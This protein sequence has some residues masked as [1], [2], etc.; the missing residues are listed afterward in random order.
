MKKPLLIAVLLISFAV[1]L[2]GTGCKKTKDATTPPSLTTADVIL[3]VTSTSA[4]SG[5]TVTSVGASAV[6]AIGVCYSSTNHT[7]TIS[8]TKTSETIGNS[9]SF[10]SNLTGLTPSTTYYVRAYATNQFGTSYGSVVT[11]TTSGTLAAVAGAV[12]TFAGNGTGGYADGTGTAAQFNSPSGI[13]VDSHGNVYVSDSFN[14]RIRKIT[15]A[16]VVTTVAGT[17]V[18]GYHDGS[19]ATA[20][21]YGPQGLAVDASGNIFVADYGNNVIRKITT[22]GVVST[23]AGNTTA[24]HVDGAAV[25]VAE[26]NSPA[27][28]AVDATGNLYVADYNNNMIRK[29]TAAGVVSTIAGTLTAGYIN[30]TTNTT[31][32]TYAS[33]N[34]PSNLVLDAS[35]NIFV[36][37]QGNSA[38]RE[39]TPAAVV[40]TIAG[41]PGQ[42]SLLGYP[43]GLALDAHGNFYIADVS[44]R[45]IELTAAKVLYDLAGS[46]NVNG[47]ADGSG[48]LAQFNSPQGIGV[49]ASGNIF[50]ADLNNNRIRKVVIVDVLN[51]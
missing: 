17:G 20:Q 42:S 13:A 19:V 22:A 40:T 21:F 30:G 43:A 34:E 2:F 44:G 41:G 12:T 1:I 35:G 6:T 25:S 50:V 5:G 39:I 46:P 45:I 14:N 49:D 36:A 18:A 3:D 29:I 16:G 33:F 28:I 9:Y 10:V 15:P 11:F 26:F 38:I 37:D 8:D 24:G 27:G 7:P 23:V 47:F 31:T 51:Q 4:Q 32:G 48:T